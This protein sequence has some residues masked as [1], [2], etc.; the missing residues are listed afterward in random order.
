MYQLQKRFN[1]DGTINPLAIAIIRL[2]DN[3]VIPFDENNVDYQQ[4]LTWLSEGNMPL[5]A[6][7]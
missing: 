2:I 6:E 4:Y 5:P 7:Y 3:A 1:K